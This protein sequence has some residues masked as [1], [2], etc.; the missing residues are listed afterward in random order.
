MR[1]QHTGQLFES[2]R[3]MAMIGKSAIQRYV[4]QSSTTPKNA[5]EAPFDPETAHVLAKRAT[6]IF[7]K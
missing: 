1:W 7:R 6:K 3:E 5:V 4:G 2:S